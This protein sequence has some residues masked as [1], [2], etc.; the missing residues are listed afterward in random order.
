ME[1][2]SGKVDFDAPLI[3]KEGATVEDVCKALHR[4]FVRKFR[5]AMVWGRSVK[6]PGQHVGLEHKLQDEDIVRLVIRR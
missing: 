2:Q 5:Y 4:D 6:F 1:P 3:L